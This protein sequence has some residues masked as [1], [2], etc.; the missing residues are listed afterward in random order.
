MRRWTSE[1]SWLIAQICLLHI[2]YSYFEMAIR[3]K[4]YFPFLHYNISEENTSWVF[5]HGVC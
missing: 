1:A 4:I 3:N 2:Y 5:F